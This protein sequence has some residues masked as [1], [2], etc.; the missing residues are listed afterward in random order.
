MSD[1][2]EKITV[3]LF[4]REIVKKGKK[5]S[6]DGADSSSNVLVDSG[7]EEVQVFFATVNLSV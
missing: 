3:F 4:S 5:S 2:C 7:H 1:V 6:A